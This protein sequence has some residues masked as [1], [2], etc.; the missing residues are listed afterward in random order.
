M[1]QHRRSL[2]LLA[3]AG[4]DGHRRL[5][6]FVHDDNKSVKVLPRH[7]D[8]C[9]S[10]R[11]CIL[12]DVESGS[13]LLKVESMNYMT[14]NPE[15]D[16]NNV[17]AERYQRGSLITIPVGKTQEPRPKCFLRG[18]FLSKEAIAIARQPTD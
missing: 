14:L 16:A 17:S 6:V 13:F 7:P 2:L 11:A 12:Y 15:H 1:E 4:W 3:N 5:V 9:F 8:T 18:T 10:G